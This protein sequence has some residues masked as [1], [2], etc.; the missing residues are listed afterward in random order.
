MAASVDHAGRFCQIS[1]DERTLLLSKRRPVVLLQK[2][3]GQCLPESFS[4][5]NSRLGVMLPYTPLHFL[6]FYHPR[7]NESVVAGPHF[8][9]LVM[10]SGN[11]SEEPIVRDNDEAIE[12]LSG[13]VDGFLLH[14]RD[15]FMR[16][17]DSVI[18]LRNAP[19]NP[20]QAPCGVRNNRSPIV[21]IDS[22]DAGH[23]QQQRD[24]LD[25]RP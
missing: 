24:R 9:A 12:K 22:R 5:G 20:G 3:P 4:P 15:I 18:R 23:E 19:T 25:I 1:H 11:L 6:L 13:I 17:D 14:N 8:E 7:G 21:S 10:T 16:V 2:E